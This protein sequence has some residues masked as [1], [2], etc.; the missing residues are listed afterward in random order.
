M[1]SISREDITADYAAL[2][3]AVT[4]ILGHSYDALSTPE[5]L[6]LLEHLETESRRLPAAG[7][8]LINQIGEQSTAEE[9]GGKLPAVLAERLRI[10]RAEA[11][12]RISEA[13]DLGPRHALT[14]ESLPPRLEATSAAQRAGTVGG[15]NIA[16]IRRFFAQ[17]PGWVDQ[18]T[19]DAAERDL[20]R[21]AA[22]YGPDTVS[23]LAERIAAH[24]DPDGKFSDEDRA[25]RRGLIIGKQGIDTMS[26]IRGW[27][28]PEARATV[29]KV[30]AKLAAP[31]MCNPDDRA[32][33]VDDPAPP[34]AVRGDTRSTAQRNHDGLNAALRALLGS[35][36]L[37]QHKGLPATIIVTA[38]LKDLEAAAGHGVTGGGTLLPMSDVIRLAR[39]AFHYLAIFDDGKAVGLYH[40]KR[41]ASPGQRIVLYAR[42]RGC[43]RPGCEV[44]GDWCECHHVDGWAATGCTDV[45]TMALACGPDNRRAEEDGWT[46][47]KNSKGET[48]WLPPAHLDRGQPRTNSFHH[49]E[50]LL[51]PGDDP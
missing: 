37:G 38:S 34:E 15:G 13:A 35:G 45:N 2:T 12:R 36:K 41:F 24:L 9:L 4:R 3:A 27:L 14:G 5:R 18:V 46:T 32:P 23:K 39:H 17:L 11:G 26:P 44:P 50:K 49:P 6:N 29:E 40:T 16:V 48:E 8:A 51:V 7:H 43:T 42:D 25:R 21:H 22:T 31:G 47:R 30:L 28:T 19:R 33:V 20:A 1:S 10:T